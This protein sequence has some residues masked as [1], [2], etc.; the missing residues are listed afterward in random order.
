MMLPRILVIVGLLPFLTGSPTPEEL[1]RQGNIAFRQESY[2]KAVDAYHQAEARTT[3]PGLAAFNQA[4]ALYRLARYREAEL[5]YRYCL[6]DAAGTR[7]GLALAGLGGALLQQGG[8]ALREAIQRYAECLHEGEL[9]DEQAEDVRHNLELAKLLMLQKPQANDSSDDRR[10]DRDPPP[11]K[12]P[13]DQGADQQPGPGQPDPGGQKQRVPRD[14]SR[15]PTPSDDAAPGSGQLPP[16]PDQDEPAPLARPDAEA[17]LKL[18]TQRILEEQRKY[19]KE[20]R[21]KGSNGATRDW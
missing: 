13:E 14:P 15:E 20:R 17:H 19:R 2:D 21:G 10:D 4:A 12:P 16:V 6:E 5:H 9:S 11:P 3:D 1:L 8:P 18:A 7:R